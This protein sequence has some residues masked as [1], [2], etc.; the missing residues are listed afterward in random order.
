MA[1]KRSRSGGFTLIE[2]MVA[3]LIVTNIMAAVGVGLTW[4]VRYFQIIAQRLQGTDQALMALRLI[5]QQMSR[6][7]CASE[8]TCCAGDMTNCMT[9]WQNMIGSPNGGGISN[10]LSGRIDTPG[11]P[12]AFFGFEYNGAAPGTLTYCTA[13]AMPA[14]CSDPAVTSSLVIARNI[15][16]GGTQMFRRNEGAGNVTIRVYILTAEEFSGGVVAKT[17][18]YSSHFVAGHAVN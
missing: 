17:K 14:N 2:L 15:M 4:S 12:S 16:N 7:N 6:V 3:I 8:A 5:E 9:R 10:F 11:A 1:G 18:T 13:S